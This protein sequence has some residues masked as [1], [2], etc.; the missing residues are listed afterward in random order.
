MLAVPEDGIVY[1][2][3]KRE[4]SRRYAFSFAD[5]TVRT[6]ESFERQ[7]HRVLD[8]KGVLLS[9]LGKW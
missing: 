4:F 1:F 3:I 7:N 9:E 8:K 2:A 5:D 6:G